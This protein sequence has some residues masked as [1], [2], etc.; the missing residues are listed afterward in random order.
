MSSYS[1]ADVTAVI[2]GPGGNFSIKEGAAEEGIS[3]DPVG[4][5]SSMT[6]G[7]DGSGMHELSASS[8]CLVTIRLLKTSPVNAKL[9]QMFNHQTGSAARH[10]KNVITLRDPVRGDFVNITEAAFKKPPPLTYAAKGGMNEWTFD[11]IHTDYKLGTG[12][13]EAEA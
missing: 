1:F 8:A 7:A 13:P 11:G 3:I 10:G 6:I 5:Q 2:D 12:T 9:M 4:D